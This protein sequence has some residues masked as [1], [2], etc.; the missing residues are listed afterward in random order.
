MKKTFKGWLF[1]RMET[2]GNKEFNHVGC[3]GD[4][5]KFIDFLTDFVPEVGMRRKVRFT[6]ETEG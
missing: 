4:D 1:N 2:L 3:E 6:V 5:E